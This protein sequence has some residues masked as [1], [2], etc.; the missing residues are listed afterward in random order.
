LLKTAHSVKNFVSLYISIELRQKYAF[1]GVLVQMFTSVFL[2]YLTI[3]KMNLPVWNAL[4][5]LMVLFNTFNT[6]A[7]GFL[8][9]S[10]GKMLYY[11]TIC[12]PEVLILSKIIFNTLL[13]LALLIGFGM[14]YALVLG[15]RVQLPLP[16][17]LI[18]VLFTIGLSAIFTMV[19]A[20]ASGAGNNYLLI[21]VLGLPLILPLLLITVK[22]AKNAMDGILTNQF[23][24][25]T[26]AIALVDIMVIYLAVILYKFLWKG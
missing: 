1:F 14:V 2:I 3:A 23:M 18:A 17:L 26:A 25:D 5:W 20:M 9:E 12:K 24:L 22:S 13:S 10:E 4:F 15:F 6:I 7:K 21:P 11:H 19:S 8:Q 16:Y